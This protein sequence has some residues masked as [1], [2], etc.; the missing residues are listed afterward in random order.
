MKMPLFGLNARRCVRVFLMATCIIALARPLHADIILVSRLS[1]AEA[2]AGVLGT[3]PPQIQ[4]DFFPATL[5][6]VDRWA[7]CQ[8]GGSCE[9]ATGTSE[10]NSLITLTTEGLAV[11]GDGTATASWQGGG[12]AWGSA[13]LMVL[14]FTLTDVSYPYSMTGQM[15]GGST[16]TLTGDNG[17]IFETVGTT[18]AE[19]GTLPPGNYTLS[20][21]VYAVVG[22]DPSYTSDAHFGF[23]LNGPATTPTPTPPPVP[24][25][26]A[27]NLSTR[28]LVGTDYNTE[29]IGGFIITGHGPRQVLVKGLGPSLSGVIPNAV[30]D[31]A[32]SLWGSP[33]CF[34]TIYNFS[35][36]ESQEA[37]IIATGHAPTNDLESAILIDLFP[38]SYTA[39]LAN[40]PLPNTTGVGLI[41]MWD[42]STDR[43]SRLANIS[44]RANV[45]TGSEIVIGGL[46]L[47]EGSIEDPIIV[48]ALGPS[49]N[50]SGL[51]GLPDPVLELRDSQGGL[52]A[53]DDNWMDDPN[54]AAII[55]GVGLAPPN[56][57]ESAIATTLLPG[58]YTALVAGVNN[59]TGTGLVEVYDNPA[60]LPT[61]TPVPTPTPAPTPGPTPIA[62]VLEAEN[63]LLTGCYAQADPNASN[64]FH[65]EGI[66]AVGDSVTFTQ[67]PAG[68][69]VMVWYTAWHNA[70]M[71]LYV[72][73]VFQKHVHFGS[74]PEGLAVYIGKEV[75]IEIPTG[76]SVR[77]QFDPGDS[78]KLDYVQIY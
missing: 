63:A 44:T 38:G 20:V 61:P 19:A 45:G 26:R 59:A 72:N 35:W 66:D 62:P 27:T 24:V 41:E 69:H 1:S 43:D 78:I 13:K 7:Y 11:V 67:V 47:G 23:A 42:L 32:L 55:Q 31:P 60:T 16:A 54:Q 9:F 37:E 30:A 2:F 56:G 10:I 5:C 3:A 22:A 48:R 6:N 75:P 4:T 52:I 76:S 14:S 36:R 73:D 64:G 77:L 58:A 21:E 33:R 65:V 68:T 40:G 15:N 12:F 29:G 70:Y 50:Q 8:Q 57:L 71:S 25:A 34:G 74:T 17:T 18:L 53:S 51:N 46:I 39:I 28:M 49:L